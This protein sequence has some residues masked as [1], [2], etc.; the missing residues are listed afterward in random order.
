MLAIHRKNCCPYCRRQFPTDTAIKRHI[1]RDPSCKLAWQD[2]LTLK[3]ATTFLVKSKKTK[4]DEP[5]SPSPS[6]DN[7][8][9]VDVEMGPADDFLPPTYEEARRSDSP[10]RSRR[11]VHVEEVEDKDASGVRYVE[12]YP[13]P[14][15]EPL[16]KGKTA[17]ETL[18]ETQ[19]AEGKEAWAPFES[20]E[21]WELATWLAK[22][23]EQKSIDEYLRL[24]TVRNR[25]NLSFHNNYTFLKKVDQ[26]P[27]G[28][29]WV[30]ETVKA[31]GDRVGEDGESLEED[32]ELWRRDPIDCIKELM[33]N[34][35][36]KEYLA[37]AP[38]RVYTDKEGANRIFDEMWTGNWWWE[39][40]DDL[41]EGAMLA[42]LI[43][44][45]DKTQLSRF[46]GDKKAWP[47][48]LTIGN[49][50]K[51]IRRQP[52]AHG[53]ILLGYLPVAKLECYS[54]SVRS[55]H[56][57]RLFHYCMSKIL[58]PLVEAGRNGVDIVC[59][60]GFLRRVHP[61]L[62]A[63]V[64]DH[65]EQC[66]VACCNEN[67]CPRCTVNPDA[68][69][70]LS[71]SLPRDVPS[72]LETLEE[73]RRG[74]TPDEFEGYG[75]RAIYAPFWHDLP[76][77]DIF[78]CIT[79]DLLHQLHKGVFKDHLVKWCTSIV[80]EAEIDAR[81]KAMAGFAGL[82]HF[83]KGIS[84]VSQWTGTEH[85]EMEKVFL[86]VL[87]GAVS[88]EVLIVARALLDFIYYSQFRSHTSKTLDALD[89]CLKTFHA[90]KD[91]FIELGIREQFNM[92]KLHSLMHYVD[93]IRALGST[94]GYNTESPERLHIDFAKAAY[95]ASNKKD[96]TE[97]M[98][99]WLQRQESIWLRDAYITWLQQLRPQ[100]K[101]ASDV[102]DLD[103]EGEDEG[104]EVPRH[105]EDSISNSQISRAG[106]RSIYR[107]SKQPA[108]RNVPVKQL[109]TN[110][111]AVDFIPA[112]SAFLRA[113]IPSCKI[114][115]S[116]FDLF[117]L[118]KQVILTLPPNRFLGDQLLTNRIRAVPAIPPRGRRVGKPGQFD[119]ALV[120]EN[121]AEYRE[122]GGFSGLRAA[123]VRAVFELPPQFG[124]YPHPLA[125]VE[126]F[127][128][129]GTPD[130]LTGMHLV[131]PSTRRHRRNVAVVPVDRL[132]RGCH[133][134]GKC[135]GSMSDKRWTTDTVL[136]VAK[137]FYLN[138]YIHVDTFS[139]VK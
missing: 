111:G 42:P 49:L 20:E 94:D 66:L 21:E 95:R 40:Q 39:T 31:K 48:Y 133:L 92:P 11:G 75:M 103:L 28:P 9:E 118:Y 62:A 131:T 61:I 134:M 51:D 36:F 82:R 23:V 76:H 132:V 139:I 30:C 120:I 15:A 138:P 52:S 74:F 3:G 113:Y 127:T 88:S 7:T 59:A 44:S 101:V 84:F 41:P 119:T 38:E 67:R 26:L 99:M 32:L 105:G 128:S 60:D 109:I 63:Y 77:C 73:H 115:P 126:W 83:K 69:G 135:V 85:K 80:G 57:Y 121:A 29:D 106:S 72:T 102:D 129:L 79:P 45:S 33:G 122:F 136:D 56:G 54:A 12:P 13:R 123:R 25:S 27:T 124:S 125:Y 58:R 14:V 17:F 55:L 8:S 2:Q 43:L 50:S 116:R 93:A 78:S 35:A 24:P 91:I 117:H 112:F 104:A 97:Q 68:R 6:L 46:Q 108:Y 1:A 18:L 130:R 19:V 64:A 110:F 98:A 10:G 86:G 70:D 65:P 53:T 4:A 16:R 22:N 5:K 137:H 89:S 71:E 114:S 107:I 100:H 81:F 34:P 37:Y 87:S 47:V 90:H 96:Y